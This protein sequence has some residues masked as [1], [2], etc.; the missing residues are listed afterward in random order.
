MRTSIS[1]FV[2]LISFLFAAGPACAEKAFLWANGDE[3]PN[4]SFQF[5]SA[6]A[7]N[8]YKKLGTGSYAVT[9]PKLSAAGR[10]FVHV[11]AYQSNAN[12]KPVDWAVKGRSREIVVAC[13]SPDGQPV[14]SQFTLFFFNGTNERR[15]ESAAYVRIDRPK[16]IR[17]TP[18]RF[19]QW[20]STQNAM[21]SF[22]RVS[23]GHYVVRFPGKR[24]DRLFG[25]TVMV[26]AVG[27]S[28]ARCQS[29][30]WSKRK[31]A[32]EVHVHCFTASG[33]PTDA[34]FTVLYSDAAS[35][36]KIKDR[37]LDIPL[38]GTYVWAHAHK[39]TRR[40][41]PIK[42][43]QLNGD[44]TVARQSRGAYVVYLR[45]LRPS[46]KTSAL[47][48]AYGREPATCNIYSWTAWE[49]SGA[50]TGTRAFVNCFDAAGQ[51]KDAQF[52]LLYQT[53]DTVPLVPY[54]GELPILLDTAAG[55]HRQ[56]VYYGTNREDAGPG[57]DVKSR[58]IGARD[59]TGRFSY[60]I[61]EVSIPDDHEMGELEAPTPFID[62]ADPKRHV[63]LLSLNEFDRGAFLGKVREA[64]AAAGSGKQ[65]LIFVHGFKVSFD[66]A[67]RRTAQLAFDLQFKGPA[68]F[69]SWPSVAGDARLTGAARYTADEDNMAWSIP[70]VRDFIKDVVRE[71]GAD[72]VHLIAHSMGTRVLAAALREQRDGLD[73]ADLAKIHTITLAAPDIDADVFVRDIVPEFRDDTAV[74]VYAADNDRALMLSAGVHGS[75]R[76][77]LMDDLKPILPS[78]IDVIDASQVQSNFAHHSYYGNN[79]SIITDIRKILSGV[80]DKAQRCHLLPVDTGTGRYWFFN[81][82][83]CN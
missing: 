30:D 18:K 37:G 58:Y 33:K 81:D 36:G 39:L 28:S 10:G 56:T 7:K 34:R 16:T 67:A 41:R 20:T 23:A 60:G 59:Y 22:R 21:N 57:V 46:N 77:G 25:G 55:Y 82:G 19:E 66:D 24:E 27:K 47:V 83:P 13:F 78:G 32:V 50:A 44:T 79:A 5:N 71:T 43:Y 38:R 4:L 31:F 75:P 14:D 26:S 45:D 65:A 68:L 69:Y 12:C 8:R 9:L 53:N 15:I 61:A 40:Y 63:L 62:P 64:V 29:G 76:T 52:L 80:T 3:T 2:G 42:K 17:Y 48:T 74:T 35:L 73:D 49:E 11:T 51:P 72:K 54:S 6:G 70:H 1:V